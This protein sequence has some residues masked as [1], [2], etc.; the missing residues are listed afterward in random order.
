VDLTWI[1]AAERDGKG[2]ENGTTPEN[3]RELLLQV[4]LYN[5]GDEEVDLAGVRLEVD[6]DR[7]VFVENFYEY[8]LADASEFSVPCFWGE[9]SLPN[10]FRKAGDK[11][12]CQWADFRMTEDGVLVTF[13]GGTL[14]PGCFLT[15]ASAGEGPVLSAKHV[16]YFPL[17]QQD[18]KPGAT[19]TCEPLEGGPPRSCRDELA[20][21]REAAEAAAS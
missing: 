16:S 9:V 8:I 11:S 2:G 10:G 19:L 7:K 14:C 18:R 4:E 6:F 1:S 3:A 20:E 15:G 12:L 17:A 13:L 5:A 21:R